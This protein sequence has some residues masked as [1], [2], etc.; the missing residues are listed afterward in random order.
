MKEQTAEWPRVKCQQESETNV[1]YDTEHNYFYP[2][3]SKFQNVFH[4][5]SQMTCP[6]T[7]IEFFQMF[8]EIWKPCN[9]TEQKLWVKFNNLNK[10][11]EI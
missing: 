9:W 5:E 10:F 11:C 4:S 3:F 6:R 2:P 7:V 1:Y 8:L